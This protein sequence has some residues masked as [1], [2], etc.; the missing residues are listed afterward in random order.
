LVKSIGQFT[1]RLDWPD[2]YVKVNHRIYFHD[3]AF[4]HLIAKK[5]YPGDQH[6]VE[7]GLL[8]LQIDAACT[9]NPVYGAQLEFLAEINTNK[10]KH[11]KKA[12]RAIKK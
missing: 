7:S 11:V 10:R 12:K 5:F 4:T 2:C 3:L 8:H 1:A 6:A 9:R